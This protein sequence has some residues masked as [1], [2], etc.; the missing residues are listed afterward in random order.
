VDLSVAACLVIQP[1]TFYFSLLQSIS[2][3]GLHQQAG[4]VKTA[5]PYIGVFFRVN[6]ERRI[7]ERQAKDKRRI[8]SAQTTYFAPL[9]PPDMG[10][11][12]IKNI[13]RKR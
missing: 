13:K 1:G 7:S 10:S 11:A 6:D 3:K 5:L 8:I 12:L 4:T 2:G 9:A